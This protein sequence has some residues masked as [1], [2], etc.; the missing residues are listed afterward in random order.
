MLSAEIVRVW[1]SRCMFWSHIWRHF[2]LV[3][4]SHN[5]KTLSGVWPCLLKLHILR[6]H[7]HSKV[8]PIYTSYPAKQFTMLWATK[9]YI[10][11]NKGIKSILVDQWFWFS[12]IIKNRSGSSSISNVYI[13]TYYTHVQTRTDAWH[14]LL[15][16]KRIHATQSKLW[17]K[18]ENLFVELLYYAKLQPANK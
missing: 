12:K 16:H 8:Q 1:I 17:W 10:D 15:S 7:I 4:P 9:K 18:K 14:S 5:L 2:C 6:S 11:K 13:W 3:L